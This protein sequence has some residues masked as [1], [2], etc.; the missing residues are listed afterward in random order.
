MNFPN[1]LKKFCL[2]NA[3][4]EIKHYDFPNL[5][6]LNLTLLEKNHFKKNFFKL[7]GLN[8]SGISNQKKMYNS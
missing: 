1:I 7:A 8:L 5:K 2:K 6:V 4:Q 3:K